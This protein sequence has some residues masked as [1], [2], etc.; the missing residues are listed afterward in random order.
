MQDFIIKRKVSFIRRLELAATTTI[1]YI[2]SSVATIFSAPFVGLR[3]LLE[4]EVEMFDKAAY[5]AN[6]NK[7]GLKGLFDAREDWK[8]AHDDEYGGGL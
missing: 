8:K 3:I 5:T 6:Q 7:D 1:T 2:F 4:S